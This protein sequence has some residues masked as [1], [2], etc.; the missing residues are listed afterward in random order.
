MFFF[1]KKKKNLHCTIGFFTA[2][3]QTSLLGTVVTDLEIKLVWIDNQ[4]YKYLTSLSNKVFVTTY[5]SVS[6]FMFLFHIA[7]T[8]CIYSPAMVVFFTAPVWMGQQIIIYECIALI[9]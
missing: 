5:G 2:N 1:K 9:I 4:V 7:Q 3:A 8:T 6:F